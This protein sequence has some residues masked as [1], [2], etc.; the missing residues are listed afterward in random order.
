[1][2]RVR[3]P[4]RLHKELRL[5]DV[6][7]ICTGATL[8]AGF[9][10]LPGLAAVQAGPALVLAYLI[11]AVPLVPAM[12]CKAEL[13]TA[14][15]RAGG[16]YYFV[17]RAMGPVLGTI[18]GLGTW[19]VLVLKVAFAL[20][21]TGA[22]LGL[23]VPDLPI[24]PV[25]LALAVA[26]GL[27]N[28]SG[29]A[30][31]G[32]LQVVLV[33]FLL[34]ALTAFLLGGLPEVHASHFQDFFAAGTGDILA[35]A[36][37]VYISYVGI[38]KVA[39]LSEEIEDPERN[40]PLGVFLSIGTAV[41]IYAAGTF[42]MVGVV[43]MDRLAGDLTP[44][45]TAAGEI[46]GSWGVVL[47]GGAALIAFTSVANAGTLSAS[48]YP[49]AMSRDR[50]LPDFLGR[51]G[52]RRTPVAAIMV[53][54]AAIA[55]VLLL[56]DPTGI[57][58]LASTFQL[59]QFSLL[60]V[61]V[62]VMRSS[63]IESYDPGYR[64]P[65]YPWLPLF[66]VVAP[67]WLIVEMG[68]MPLLFATALI[69]G[70]G[71]WYRLYAR[72]RV[73]RGG[74][75]YHLFRRLGARSDEDLD[76]ELRGILKEKGLRVQDPF[77][78]VVTRS[79]VIDLQ[80]PAR[81]EELVG[82]VSRW[83]AGHVPASAATLEQKLLEGTRL[84]VTPVTR[85][86]ALPH[87]RLGGLDRPEMVLVR[88]RSGVRIRSGSD[89]EEGREET[90]TA[91]FFLASPE[92]DPG[93]HLRILAQLASRVD[94][95]SFPDDW[96]SACDDQEIREALLRDERFLSLTLGEAT[97][98]APLVGRP[99]GAISMPADTLVAI[100]LRD[101]EAVVPRGRTVLAPGDRLTII[102]GSAGIRELRRRWMEG[103]SEG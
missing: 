62:L 16:I 101:G 79:Q 2:A 91:V 94:E 52:A 47:L 5:L 13:A 19:L 41:L 8:S 68:W 90:V 98:T 3:D 96:D 18:S 82:R 71:L 69:L 74:A 92:E 35:T 99:L 85:G 84:G 11:A 43:P 48:R 58:K 102:G 67:L 32:R 51:L 80:E 66:G 30:T 10:L 4:K 31:S 39:S 20:V 86:I 64:A 72:A 59:L 6:Y 50:L 21:G 89:T 70:G 38:T 73:R 77:E 36:G 9:F 33:V 7:A 17:D 14:M 12:M 28:L 87:I 54:V 56:L 88:A 44:A 40:I 46:F 34:V 23:F 95:E 49:L 75:I 83:L 22:Y 42:V 103:R 93:Q 53:T 100:I 65:F 63:G 24:L 60:C 45:A 37:L 81:F 26:V 97:S 76:R 15:P 55:T 57:A 61:A 1:M 25:A 27:V 29:A 78:E